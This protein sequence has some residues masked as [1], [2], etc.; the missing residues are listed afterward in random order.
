VPTPAV[1][2]TISFKGTSKTL[3]RDRR[4]RFT[5]RFTATPKLRGTF[6]V[7]AVKRGAMKTLKGTFTADSKGVVKLTLKPG[8]LRGRSVKLRLTVVAGTARATHPFTLR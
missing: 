8:K 6:T 5:L 1:K 4:G 2:P 3:K 7:A